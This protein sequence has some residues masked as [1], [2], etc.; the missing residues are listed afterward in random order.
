MLGMESR[1]TYAELNARANRLAHALRRLGVGPETLVGICLERTPD[2]GVA[3][4]GVLKAGGAYLPLDPASPHERLRRLVT[5]TRPVVVLAH[6]ALRAR[7]PAEIGARVVYLD[8]EPPMFA[9]EPAATPEA[10]TLPENLAY[11]IYTSGTTGAPKGVQVPHRALANHGTTLARSYGLASRDRVLQFASLSFD[12]AAEEL[13]PTW[14]AGAC[15]VLRTEETS[16][17]VS[18]FLAWVEREGVTVLNLPAPYW[19][20]L[21]DALAEPGAPVLPACLRLVV[22]GSDQVAADRW[23]R[24]QKGVGAGVRLVNAYGPTEATITATLYEDAAGQVPVTGPTVPIGRPIALVETHLLDGSLR[25]VPAGE[26]G[27]LY[28]GGAGLARGYLGDSALTAERFIP[29]PWSAAPGARLYRTGDRARHR[30]DGTL[31]YLGR[32]DT[33]VKVR[34]YRVELGEIEAALCRHPAVGGSAVAVRAAPSGE[35]RLAAYA[36]PLAGRRITVSELREHLLACLPGYMVPS[37]FMLLE[38]FPLTPGGKVDRNA[39]PIPEW[40]GRLEKQAPGERAGAGVDPVPEII[41]GIW[42]QVLGLDRVGREGSFFALGGHS[43]LATQIVSR[44]RDAFQVELPLRS[45]FENPTVM[46]LAACVQAARREAQGLPPPAPLRSR[47]RTG[48]VPL[49]FAQ[50]RQWFLDQLVPDRP[51][52][53]IHVALRMVGR[54]EVAALRRSL[55]ALLRRHEVLRTIF[56]AVE[57][58]PDQVILPK[59]T[60]RLPVIDL[61]ALPREQREEEVRRLSNA[62]ARRPFDLGRGPLLRARLIRLASEEHV[63][64]ITM[65]HIVSDGWSATV[66]AREL[67]VLYDAYRSGDAAALPAPTIQYAD[68]AIWQREWMQGEQ[69]ARQLDYWRRQL[70]GAPALLRLPADRPRLATHSFNGATLQFRLPDVL[71]VRLKELSRREGVT[72]FMTLLAGFQTLLLRY[73][74]QADMVLGS[75]IAG[76][77]RTETEGLIGFF[78]NTLV[79]RTD[80]AGDPPFRELL[81]RVREVCLDAYAHQDLPFEKLVE[82]LAPERSLSHTPLVQVMFQLQTVATT[83]LEL[84]GLSLC[85]LDVESGTTQFD[86]SVDL[87]E[88]PEGLDAVLE[89]STDLFDAATITRLM[90]GYQ[91]LLEAAVEAPER[92]LSGLPLLTEEERRTVLGWS[93]VPGERPAAACLHQLVEAQTRRRP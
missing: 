65:H 25:Q 7:L 35:K 41:A 71:V 80:L 91:T 13:F 83:T 61:E 10:P 76:R 22:V 88:G 45:L 59:L 27:E 39:L 32:G 33:Q 34:G 37:A 46:Q 64:L 78:V 79:L 20:T 30:A 19:H 48:H 51:I 31:E 24:W 55:N 42:A 90:T 14:I 29:H 23:A 74:N 85:A 93:A 16:L 82:D 36:V 1:L 86:L 50:E 28:I 44:I 4:L 84:T 62:E 38:S 56:V 26:A 11:V 69:L 8:D 54:L 68:F 17:V 3:V 40:A 66:S 60:I 21:V 77:M 15:A 49:S 2:L 52:Y 43:L 5:E 92:R 9:P 18:D 47:P 72:L 53:N 73:T 6:R 67:A 87:L 57:G 70:A 58:R 75:P 63:L 89:Y 81:R 12:V